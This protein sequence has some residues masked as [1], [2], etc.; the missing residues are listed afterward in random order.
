MVQINISQNLS[1][2]DYIDRYSKWMYD[3]YSDYIGKSVFDVGAGMGRMVD[4]YI[5]EVEKVTATDIFQEQVDFMNK[6]FEQYL[7]FHAEL[8]DILKDALEEYEGKFD[9]VLCINVL[10]HLLDDYK[11]VGNMKYILRDGGVLILMVPAFQKLYCRLDSA[12]NHYRRYDPGRLVDIAEKNRMEI[13]RHHYFNI[14]GIIPYWLKGK[15][16]KGQAGSFSLSLNE[17]NSRIYNFAAGIM[18]P[19]EKRFPPGIGL[20]EVIILRKQYENHN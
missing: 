9:T 6:R 8:V 14:L 20:T 18:E 1:H 12:V 19:I 10:E 11:A 15:S 3:V 13:I 16:R 4:F 7:Y 17:S 2:W 5:R